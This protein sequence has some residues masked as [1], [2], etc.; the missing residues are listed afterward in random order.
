Y[1]GYIQV[2]ETMISSVSLQCP[3]VLL[4]P[5]SKASVCF[6]QLAQE[7]EE[8]MEGQ[9]IDSFSDFWRQQVV[10]SKVL[11]PTPSNNL[12]PDF[13]VKKTQTY[14]PPA[15]TK[16]AIMDFEQASSF[17]L[18]Q[19][20]SGTLND[21][22]RAAFINAINEISPPLAKPGNLVTD[23]SSIRA[24]YNYLEKKGFP[25]EEIRDVVSTLE[26]IYTEKYHQGIHS[27]ESSVLR[28]FSR[29]SGSEDE[30]RYVHSQ[31]TDS[32]QRQFDQPLYNVIDEIKCLAQSKNLE[33]TF[34]DDVLSELLSSYQQSFSSRYK[35][36]ADEELQ[37]TKQE[38]ARLKQQSQQQEELLQKEA[39]AKKDLIAVFHKIQS[40]LPFDKKGI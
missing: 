5:E 13:S 20:K 16:P 9:T 12:N 14:S 34:F 28:L 23:S 37:L 35:T 22:K 40:L 2:D 25:Q 32:Y 15:L 11:E 24:F 8:K 19:L 3:A 36:K 29:F 38:L 39:S 1:L 18:Q 17:C 26:Q 6:K 27:F 31:L 10:E 4:N 21:E 7:L 30:L 33:Q